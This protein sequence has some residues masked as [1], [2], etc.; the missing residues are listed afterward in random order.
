MEKTHYTLKEL[1]HDLKVD[2]RILREFISKGDLRATKVGR[3][4]LVA[5]GDLKKFLKSNVDIHKKTSKTTKFSM[6]NYLCRYYDHCLSDAALANRLFDCKECESFARA[7]KQKISV[8]ELAGVLAL[9]ES[10]FGSE[11]F[12]R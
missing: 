11:V 4:Y 3:A 5:T 7:E 6:R 10:V 9:W 12:L 1:S 2:V 8:H